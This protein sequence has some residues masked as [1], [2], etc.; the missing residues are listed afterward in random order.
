[1]HLHGRLKLPPTLLILAAG[2]GDRFGGAKQLAEVGP[3]GATLVDY[4]IHDARRAGFLDVV[5]VTRPEHEE[6]LRSQVGR[7]TAGAAAIRFVHQD[8]PLG[9]GHAVLCAE[10]YLERPFAVANADDFYGTDAW[11]RLYDLLSG[12]QEHNVVTVYPLRTTLSP[13]GGVS[14]AVCEV[15]PDG[16]LTGIMELLDVRSEGGGLR[17]QTVDGRTVPLVGDEPVSMNLWGLWPALLPALRAS[18]DRFREAGSGVPAAG[19]SPSDATKEEFRLSEAMHELIR[20]GEAS[21]RVA[22]VS[23]PWFGLT[24]PEDLPRV[25]GRIEELIDEGAYPADLSAAMARPERG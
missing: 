2:L 3:G 25:R 7:R 11:T 16:C 19:R 18:F 14:R 10:R 9:T 21:V 15:D 20:R 1:M 6:D 17:G 22:P 12:P 8:R 13:F 4:A 5:I 23:G 24:W